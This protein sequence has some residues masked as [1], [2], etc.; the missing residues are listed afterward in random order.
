MI[1][2]HSNQ[3]WLLPGSLDTNLDVLRVLGF[4]QLQFGKAEQATV[5]FEALRLIF[6]NDPTI[7]FSLAWAYLQISDPHSANTVL[8]SI[9]LEAIKNE[10]LIQL[11]QDFCF[12]WLRSRALSGVGQSAEAGRWMRLFLRLRRQFVLTGAL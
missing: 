5:I 8:E 10:D 7:G 11:Q 1:L 3:S 12:C 9:E 2:S 4:F 6:P